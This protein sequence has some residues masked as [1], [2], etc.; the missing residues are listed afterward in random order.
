MGKYHISDDG[1]VRECHADFNS[2]RYGENNHYETVEDAQEAYEEQNEAELFATQQ[3]LMNTIEDIYADD[4]L[5]DFLVEDG[6][7]VDEENAV[8]VMINVEEKINRHIDLMQTDRLPYEKMK[9]AIYLGVVENEMDETQLNVAWRSRD[10][11]RIRTM[12]ARSIIKLNSRADGVVRFDEDELMKIV[13]ETIESPEE[14][15]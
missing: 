1:V 11:N 15:N 4:E 14:W 13:K 7:T 2:C 10:Y 12:A 8:D 3:L 5:P 6:M 9:N